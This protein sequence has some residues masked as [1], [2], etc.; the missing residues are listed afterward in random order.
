MCLEFRRVPGMSCEL[1]S[2]HHLDQWSPTFSAAETG[3]MED[4]FFHGPGEGDGLGMIQARYICC[5]LLFLLLLQ[6]LHL[7]SLGIRSQRLGIPWSRW[8]LKPQNWMNPGGKVC[9]EKGKE[10]YGLSYG[11]LQ[12][13]EVWWAKEK[14]AKDQRR[15]GHWG[16]G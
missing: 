5:T 13:I 11:S 6:R 3:F 2:Y 12:C 14:L 8:Y 1:G 16:R 4:T 9:R 7:R 10:T 15:C